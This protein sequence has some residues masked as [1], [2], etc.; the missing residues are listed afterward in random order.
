[1]KE[2]K[3]QAEI[4][5]FLKRKGCYVIKTTPGPGVPVG[6]PDIIALFEGCWIAIEVK[7][8]AKSAFRPLQKETIA[9]LS[10]WS[11]CKAVTLDNWE[12]TKKQLEQFIG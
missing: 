1:M 11:W 4:I 12:D 10:E 6:C 9:K 5:R 7:A 8:N 3:L 2:S